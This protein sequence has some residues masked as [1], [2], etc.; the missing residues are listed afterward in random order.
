MWK[1]ETQTHKNM[2]AKQYASKQS[3]DQWK[4]SKKKSINGDK[5]KQKYISS[6]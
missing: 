6:K 4:K 5:R 1:K 3:M 2:E